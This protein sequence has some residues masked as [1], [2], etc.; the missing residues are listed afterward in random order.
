MSAPEFSR[1]VKA[2]QLPSVPLV[3]QPTAEERA[4]LALRFGVVAIDS[5]HAEV[6]L[7]PDKQAILAEGWLRAD[8]VQNCAVSTEDFPVRIEEPLALRF[9]PPPAQAPEEE[10]EL[11]VE[12]CDEIE[13]E[14][15]SFDLGEAVA[16]SL[17]LAIDP[18][19]RGPDADTV[20]REAGLIEE[21]ASGPLAEALAAL[22]KR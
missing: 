17:G 5:L 12:D 3:L 2:R 21:G 13:F 10:V 8:L 7:R 19:A 18:Y 22:R 15:D 20:R 9:V 4:A 6:S 1:L 14:S 16:Q 11:D